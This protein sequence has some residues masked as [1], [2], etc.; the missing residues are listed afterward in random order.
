MGGR[1]YCKSCASLAGGPPP[2]PSG[3]LQQYGAPPVPPIAP[4]QYGG[5]PFYQQQYQPYGYYPPPRRYQEIFPGAN[6]GPG[7]AVII[8]FIA[9]AVSTGVSLALLQIFFSSSSSNT[10]SILFLFM[11]SLVLYVV[12]LGGVYYSV[13]SR[14]D[15][16]LKAIG[17]TTKG[18]GRAVEWGFGLGLPLFV[19]ALGLAFVSLFFYNILYRDVLHRAVPQSMMPSLSSQ[20]TSGGAIFLYVFT[21]VVLAP[22]CEEIFFRGYLYPSFRNRMGMQAAMLLNGAFFSAVHFQLAGFLPRFLI[23]YGLCY[24]YERNR[25]LIAPMIGHALYNGL[26][27]LLSGV[28]GLF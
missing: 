8:F 1:N 3:A 26:L 7:E 24:M 23:G 2:A 25:T 19:G 15:S 11:S 14:H 10:S 12:M 20:G 6:W 9:L 16:D 28:F 22:V 18:A 13:V 21:L 17:L 27:V 4:Q 5:P